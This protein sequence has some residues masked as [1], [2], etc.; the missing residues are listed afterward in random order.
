MGGEGVLEG[1]SE[2]LDHR[3]LPYVAFSYP[4]Y[5]G[6]RLSSRPVNQ[7]RGEGGVRGKGGSR[8]RERERKARAHTHSVRKT[9]E[10]LPRDMHSKGEI[11]G[12]GERHGESEREADREKVG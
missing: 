3:H 6:V 5:A 9:E 8:E 12:V 7:Q 11:W 10:D 2:V 4:L 1:L